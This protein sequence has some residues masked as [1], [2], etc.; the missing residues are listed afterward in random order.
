MNTIGKHKIITIQLLNEIK[1]LLT[2]IV[3]IDIETNTISGQRFAFPLVR[4]LRIGPTRRL[5]L[6]IIPVPL[7]QCGATEGESGG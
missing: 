1:E 6:Y 2:N 5:T 7:P 3:F 4:F